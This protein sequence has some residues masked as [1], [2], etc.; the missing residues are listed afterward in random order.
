MI[1]LFLSAAAFGLLYRAF[2]AVQEKHILLAFES[3]PATWMCIDSIANEVR[4]F[5]TG[6]RFR[7]L[8]PYFQWAVSPRV[9]KLVRQGRLAA[10][11]V[12][13]RTEPDFHLVVSAVRLEK[14]G[15]PPDKYQLT[16]TGA[17]P[18]RPAECVA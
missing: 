3:D 5:R 17:E 16:A 2:L 14:N 9:E 6:H 10:Q 15:I 11:P 12:D 1:T 7:F 4:R 13:Y 8:T 18:A